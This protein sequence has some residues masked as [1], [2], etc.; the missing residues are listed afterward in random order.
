MT[1]PTPTDPTA[2]VTEAHE[3]LMRSL[4]DGLSDVLAV[5]DEDEGIISSWAEDGT[6][7]AAR[8]RVS[9][10]VS[11]IE[12]PEVTSERSAEEQADILDAQADL[13]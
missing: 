13:G 4:R 8:W 2:V 1:W 7:P 5:E 3:A 11:L 12:E 6:E 10:S 9:V